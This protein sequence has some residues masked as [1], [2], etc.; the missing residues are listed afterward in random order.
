M[1]IVP[2]APCT[3]PIILPPSRRPAR[4]RAVEQRPRPTRGLPSAL[5][6]FFPDRLPIPS[7][8]WTAVLSSPAT[9]A[10]RKSPM[11]PRSPLILLCRLAVTVGLAGSLAGPLLC[12]QIHY[13]QGP[14]PVS[15]GTRFSTP[16][17]ELSNGDGFLVIW[18]ENI[19]R[20]EIDSIRGAWCSLS[21]HTCGRPF[22]VLEPELRK[23]VDDFEL[24]SAGGNQFLV[25]WRWHD[26]QYGRFIDVGDTN[27]AKPLSI[28]PE[29]QSCSRRSLRVSGSR[30]GR[31]IATWYPEKATWDPIRRERRQT[32]QTRELFHGKV[33]PLDL[34]LWRR[35]ERL[36]MDIDPKGHVAFGAEVK[37]TG[38]TDPPERRTRSYLVILEASGGR[39]LAIQRLD[40]QAI[41][42]V[43]FLRTGIVLVLSQ[44]EPPWPVLS[45]ATYDLG[46]NLL[47]GPFELRQLSRTNAQLAT[48]RDGYALLMHKVEPSSYN[49]ADQPLI[50]LAPD[51]SVADERPIGLATETPDLSLNN[52]GQF[53]ILHLKP[54]T[55]PE[56][57]VETGF[58]SAAENSRP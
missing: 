52:R 26:E 15:G 23:S 11:Q 6:D 40:G 19:E 47:H 50:L 16:K 17:L 5:L 13:N 22:F 30:T 24:Y 55:P 33:W 21:R 57:T 9:T 8:R 7:R 53:A 10:L 31:F 51:G 48:N 29:S 25:T 4:V 56:V 36:S 12:A 28:V 3:T 37:P 1:L 49:A 14:I 45:S 2:T 43:A 32:L 20:N 39:P 54:G 18:G 41:V 27:W 35:V 46:G 38:P 34:G 42:D 44:N 58:I